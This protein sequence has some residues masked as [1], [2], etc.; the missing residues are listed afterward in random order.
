[1]RT[2]KRGNT[3]ND[4]DEVVRL[5]PQAV[6][7]KLYKIHNADRPRP[8]TVGV[9]RSAP[10][11]DCVRRTTTKFSRTISASG[12]NNELRIISL[13]G[14]P[15]FFRLPLQ[16]FEDRSSDCAKAEKKKQ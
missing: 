6:V 16:L 14:W 4:D 5:R 15:F 10:P 12:A 1:M 2:Q 7:V 3:K 11:T 13:C 8:N 9:L